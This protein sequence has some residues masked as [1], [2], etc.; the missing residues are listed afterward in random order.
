MA[1]LIAIL[2]SGIVLSYTGTFEEGDWVTYTNFRYVT[3]VATDRTV[4]YFGTTGGVIRYDRYAKKWLDPLT[5]TDGIPDDWIDN[6]AYDPDWD[7][8][9]V[10]T[11]DGN[12]YYQPTFQRWYRGGDFPLELAHND[13]NRKAF[14][15]LNTEFGYS[16]HDGMLTDLNMQEFLLTKGVDDG[17]DNLFVGTWGMGPVVINTRYRDLT[18]M[19]YGPYSANI[20]TII[21]IGDQ[22]WMGDGLGDL[23]AGAIT[24][25]DRSVGEWM[26]FQPRYVS[27]LA[28]AKLTSATAQNSTI[29]LGTEYGLACYDEKNNSFT[30]YADFSMLPSVAV[31]S[32]TKDGRQ[33]FAG[34]DNGLGYIDGRSS[35]GISKNTEPSDSMATGDT[36]SSPIAA[37]GLEK[38][39]LIGW[40]I[41]KVDIIGQY[42]YLA[43][44]RGAL[45]RQLD[46]N[47]EFEF[48]N[49][50]NGMLSTEIYDIVSNG[51]SL[52]F[53]TRNDIVIIDLETEDYSAVTDHSYFGQWQLRRIAVDGRNIWAATDIG[54]WK[55]RLKDGFS[56]LF[57]VGDGMISDDIRNIALDGDYIWMATPGGL[58]RFYWNDP[59]RID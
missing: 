4:V 40:H 49:T 39:R 53:V 24:R 19:P 6:I 46:E 21:T 27:G 37:I 5:V 56:R 55:Y 14:P 3:S 42:L 29:W 11:P 33:V 17:Y 15:L 50:P 2:V 44:D 52:Y 10:A 22:L 9:W 12:A 1:S 48:V 35:G 38:Q 34:T 26:W 41:N 23:T 47:A 51:D 54:L 28:S 18:I 32:V 57:T 45:R 13:F 25:F 8:I 31:S 58:I 30:A 7:R 16:Y 36:G 43:T 20:S 59:G